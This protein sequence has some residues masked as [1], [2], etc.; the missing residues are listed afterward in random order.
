MRRHNLLERERYSSIFRINC[1]GV[2]ASPNLPSCPGLFLR[3]GGK[4]AWYTLHAHAP[5]SPLQPVTFP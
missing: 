2:T 4:G 1:A 5:V 3:G